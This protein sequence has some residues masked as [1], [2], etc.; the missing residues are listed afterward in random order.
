MFSKT[1]SGWQPVQNGT[2]YANKNNYTLY[3]Q[4]SFGLQQVVIPSVPSL[5]KPTLLRILVI[6]TV[7]DN[8]QPTSDQ[9]GAYCDLT[10]YP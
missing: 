1:G 4:E 5:T 10:L 6:G 8:D 7:Y 3:P 9:E 2:L